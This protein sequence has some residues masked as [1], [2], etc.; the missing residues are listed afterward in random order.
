MWVAV[1]CLL[2][3]FACGPVSLGE[4]LATA[5]AGSS[6]E[7]SGR[8][9]AGASDDASISMGNSS[10]PSANVPVV[11]VRIEPLDC[12]RCFE[13]QAQGSGGQPPYRFEWEDGSS[14]A[15]RRVCVDG[16]DAALSV[17]AHDASD[18]LSI[19]Q[20][21]S[22]AGADAD[23]AQPDASDSAT[24]AG[25]TSVLCLEN[26]SFEGAPTDFFVAGGAFDAD[27]WTACTNPTTT[28]MP[29]IGNDVTSQTGTVPPPTDG[30]TY[31]GLGEGQQ[32]SQQLCRDVRGG[33]TVHLALDLARVQLGGDLVPQTEKVFLQIYGGL[34]V[35]CSQNELLWASSELKPDWQHFCVS[36]KPQAYTTQITLRGGSDMSLPSPAYLLVDNLQPV[37]RCP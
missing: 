7:A 16:P 18:T 28:N 10:V 36:L 5:Q 26:P 21:I 27:P 3:I 8:A 30:D 14:D 1:L 32:V 29:M 22:L 4:E 24:D 11:S 15:E 2:L 25:T 12:G 13:L 37:E 35:D 17:V 31:L 9:G 33:E 34:S 6:S 20:T 23:C 19:R